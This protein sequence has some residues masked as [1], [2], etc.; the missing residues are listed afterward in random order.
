M[1]FTQLCSGYIYIYGLLCLF[2]C[3]LPPHA[4]PPPP[5][6]AAGRVLLICSFHNL[7]FEV[8]WCCLHALSSSC[9][10][11]HADNREK[12]WNSKTWSTW[13]WKTIGWSSMGHCMLVILWSFIVHYLA[14]CLTC[15]LMWSRMML[16]GALSTMQTLLK[17]WMQ[18]KRLLFLFLWRLLRVMFLRSQ[19]G[20]LGWLLHGISHFHSWL[21]MLF[22]FICLLFKNLDFLAWWLDEDIYKLNNYPCSL[23]FPPFLFNIN[24]QQACVGIC[25]FG[26]FLFNNLFTCLVSCFSK[27]YSTFL[28]DFKSVKKC[29]MNCQLHC[30]LNVTFCLVC[31]ATSQDVFSWLL[32]SL[33][34]LTC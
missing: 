34:A 12:I 16:L 4:S 30:V 2:F 15:F 29:I 24:L 17:V 7:Y 9:P 20:L 18:S 21:F 19:L 3:S 13:L 23:F 6:P 25:I 28:H 10:C 11:F 26:F 1:Y 5:P 14:N 31:D 22:F 32:H 33:L 8:D 27:I